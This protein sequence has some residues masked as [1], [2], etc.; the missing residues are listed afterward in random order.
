MPTLLTLAVAIALLG[1][2][3]SLALA[4]DALDLLQWLGSWAA[5]PTVGRSRLLE[6][7]GMRASNDPTKVCRPKSIVKGYESPTLFGSKSTGLE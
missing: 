7:K 1:A 2:A 6:D 3:F 5:T 4:S